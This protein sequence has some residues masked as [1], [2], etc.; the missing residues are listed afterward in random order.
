MGQLKRSLVGQTKDPMWDK[1]VNPFLLCVVLCISYLCNCHLLLL[2]YRMLCH[3][4]K[5][6]NKH[7][8]LIWIFGSTLLTSEEI[9][10]SNFKD[11]AIFKIFF[12][13]LIILTD[14]GYPPTHGKFHENN[15]K[16]LGTLP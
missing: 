13:K 4:L 10:I 2:Y 15:K 8:S 16:N 9:L 7:F 11:F 14:G 12:K 3:A 6:L 5:P 1:L